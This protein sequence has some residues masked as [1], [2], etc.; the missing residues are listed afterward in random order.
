MDGGLKDQAAGLATHFSQ[1]GA[2]THCCRGKTTFD[3]SSNTHGYLLPPGLSRM[4]WTSG[5]YWCPTFF[6]RARLGGGY[7][8]PLR[9]QTN[10]AKTLRFGLVPAD[11]ATKLV[12]SAGASPKRKSVAS[13]FLFCSPHLVAP[14]GQA[15]RKHVLHLSAWSS[16]A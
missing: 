14:P 3:E 9:F 15:G 8:G 7:N 2:R 5:I 13:S 10:R 4:A 1:V 16:N 12:N 11:A 6:R